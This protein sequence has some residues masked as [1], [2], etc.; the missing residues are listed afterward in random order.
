M[1]LSVPNREQGTIVARTREFTYIGSARIPTGIRKPSAVLHLMGGMAKT[2]VVKMQTQIS[3]AR[4]A[5]VHSLQNMRDRRDPNSF[6]FQVADHAIDLLLSPH[7]PEGPYLVKNAL[8]DA[9]S[10]LIR[11]KRR[12]QRRGMLPLYGD[13]GNGDG[14]ELPRSLQ[15]DPVVKAAR[16][17]SVE[18]ELAW[19]QE[20]GQLLL[21]ISRRNA[22][23]GE[24][25]TGWR[26]G[27]EVV[28]TANR[29]QISTHY[30][31]K[32]RGAIREQAFELAV[33]RRAA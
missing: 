23:A 3:A 31:K 28:E 26:L 9:R 20:F 4:W 29:L 7:R 17:Q 6:E 13:S 8:R 25:L 27:E 19:K 14:L 24:V 21:A 22:R 18:T 2:E 10:V 30:A 1:Q 33:T 5:A 15:S 16:P 32:L 11:Q 12:A